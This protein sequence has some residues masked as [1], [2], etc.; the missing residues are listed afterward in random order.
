[1]TT[2]VHIHP[3]QKRKP[4]KV[5]DQSHLLSLGSMKL[6]IKRD[7][8]AYFLNKERDRKNKNHHSK[9]ED[10]R[11]PQTFSESESL[12][13]RVRQSIPG[14]DIEDSLV[15]MLMKRAKNEEDINAFSNFERFLCFIRQEMSW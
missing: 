14:K 12:P 5:K 8:N 4:R 11:D 1:M 3:T 6:N 15:W 10:S 13:D 7:R 9:E 2:N